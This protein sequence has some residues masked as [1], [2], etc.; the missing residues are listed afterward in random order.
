M[1]IEHESQ[2]SPQKCGRFW[3]KNEIGE[4]VAELTYFYEDAHTINANHTFVDPCLRG[5]GVADKP[6]HALVDFVQAK[7]LILHP[8]CSYIMAKWERDRHNR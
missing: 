3:V 4:M 5:Q 6:Y 8:T 1:N 2:E 7:Q